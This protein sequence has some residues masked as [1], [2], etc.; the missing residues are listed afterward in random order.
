MQIKLIRNYGH[1]NNNILGI[2]FSN[3]ANKKFIF[4]KYK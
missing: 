1:I 3:N 2:Q 4:N